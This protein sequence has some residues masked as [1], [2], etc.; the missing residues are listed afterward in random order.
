ME[1]LIHEAL[2]QGGLYVRGWHR[3]TR[4]VPEALPARGGQLSV[5]RDGST[6][7]ALGTMPGSELRGAGS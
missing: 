7:G 3:G 1:A 6:L 2:L 5:Q 4:G